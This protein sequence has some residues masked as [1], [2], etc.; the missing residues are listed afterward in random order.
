[1]HHAE[2]D[3]LGPARRTAEYIDEIILAATV[4]PRNRW[5]QSAVRCRRRP[6]H[7]KC[8][9]RLL[10]CERGNGDIGYKCLQCSEQGVIRGWQD[11]MSDL[12]EFREESCGPAFEIVLREREYDEL[13]K[14]LYMDIES[15][16]IIYGATYTEQGVI[17]RA[18]ASDIK[19]FVSC[20]ADD[21]KQ[22]KNPRHLRMI[23]EVLRHVE[24]ALGT[25]SL[26]FRD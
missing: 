5:K 23:N 16:T 3:H 8:P 6:R 21:A 15:D 24:A 2:K 17:L 11:G 26:S 12:S 20:L 4:S 1:M 10:V 19:S 7:R 18:S 9:G 22:A 13:K 14:A 25:S